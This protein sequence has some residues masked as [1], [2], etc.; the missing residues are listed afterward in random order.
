MRDPVRICLAPYLNISEHAKN[1]S[2][3]FLCLQ[4]LVGYVD[5]CKDAS[6]LKRHRFP[7]KVG[8]A[9]AWLNPVRLPTE[10]QLRCSVTHQQMQ[11]LLQVTLSV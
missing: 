9:P 8:G 11:F 4:W 3:T 10:S 7:S 1:C 5:E 2:L 6:A